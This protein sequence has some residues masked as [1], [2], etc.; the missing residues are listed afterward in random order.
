MLQYVLIVQ[1]SNYILES[2]WG[3]SCLFCRGNLYWDTWG[4]KHVI[5]I[6]ICT[7]RSPNSPTRIRG[8]GL[9]ALKSSAIVFVGEEP[10]Y[11][12]LLDGE[13]EV[14]FLFY[15]EKCCPKKYVQLVEPAFSTI[16]F[17]W[18]VGKLVT[19]FISRVKFKT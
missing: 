17:F 15:L 9:Q 6:V 19:I 4:G 3:L 5:H 11:L 2:R 8:C 7:E 14:N 12:T 10:K 16:E 1:F 18:S 13:W